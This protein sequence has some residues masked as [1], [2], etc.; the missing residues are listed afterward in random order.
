MTLLKYFIQLSCMVLAL[1]LLPAFS[2]LHAQNAL[3][4]GASFTEEGLPVESSKNAPAT[5]KKQPTKVVISPDAITVESLQGKWPPPSQ[6]QALEP[7]RNV[8]LDP[9]RKELAKVKKDAKETAPIADTVS[10]ASRAE[11]AIARQT[12]A[13]SQLREMVRITSLFNLDGGSFI[14]IQIIPTNKLY[15]LRINDPQQLALISKESVANQPK[16][17]VRMDYYQVPTGAGARQAPKLNLETITLRLIKIGSKQLL[18][19][20]EEINGQTFF[21][22]E[23]PIWVYEFNGV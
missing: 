1:F 2:R 11:M 13:W 4:Q 16:G 22:E 8:F 17:T 7:V 21:G 3:P 23:Q 9:R 15:H 14:V 19:Q 6:V 12:Q 18:F 5:P 20:I 10:A